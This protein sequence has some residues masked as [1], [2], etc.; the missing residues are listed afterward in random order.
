MAGTENE[1]QMEFVTEGQL[2]ERGGSRYLIYEESEF[3][4][5]PGCKT[6]LKLTG[7]TVRMR[8]LG[9]ELGYGTELVFEKGKRFNSRYRTPYG[10][11]D[12]EVLTRDVVYNLTDEGLGDID[13]DYQ[14]SLGGVAEGHNRLKI[15]VTQ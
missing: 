13:I 14:V 2:Y 7:D 11:M 8:R 4:G 5:F 3:S 10:D 15:Q 1:D 9:S 12:M 6:T